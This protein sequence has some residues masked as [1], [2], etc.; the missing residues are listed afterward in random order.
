MHI[1]WQSIL[2]TFIQSCY[3]LP[4][5]LQ[6]IISA[7]I[8]FS[9]HSLPCSFLCCFYH[10]ICAVLCVWEMPSP[11]SLLLRNK[12]THGYKSSQHELELDFNKNYMRVAW[13]FSVCEVM[14]LTQGLGFEFVFF[15]ELVGILW[16]LPLFSTTCIWGQVKTGEYKLNLTCECGSV[17]LFLTLW[18]DVQGMHEL[19]SE[20]SLFCNK[21]CGMK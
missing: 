9:K 12:S 11:G 18:C 1:G 10:L 16:L 4:L 2:F 5:P 15:V 17:W 13:W 20:H 6:A 19:S 3:L 21:Y 14:V 7:F 8:I